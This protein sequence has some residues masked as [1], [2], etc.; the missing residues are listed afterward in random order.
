MKIEKRTLIKCLLSIALFAY[1]LT[2]VVVSRHV[3]AATP[4]NGIDICVN[5]TLNTG[6]ITADDVNKIIGDPMKKLDTLKRGE[7]NTLVI[8]KKLD[9]C[10][11]IESSRVVILANGVLRIDV[12]PMIPVARVFPAGKQSYYVNAA[13]KRITAR[14]DNNIDVPIISGK[15]PDVAAV[16]PLLPM[17]AKLKNDPAAEA[18]A[19]QIDINRRG[20]IT[21]IPA[22]LGHIVVFGDTAD[23]QSKIDRLKTFYR[24][25]MPVKGWNYY[26]TISV[27]W[28]GRIVATR[29]KK[30]VKVLNVVTDT[31]DD[32]PDDAMMTSNPEI[33]R[34]QAERSNK[35][36]QKNANK[37]TN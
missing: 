17:L 23:F 36:K 7:I 18:W 5:D 2:A 22:V 37:A 34:E 8:E 30:D 20:D 15:I 25:V 9:A 35:T 33:M 28:G 6:F 31:I 4:F 19:S 32:V 3:V 29:R 13:G 11:N 1:L 26:D 14:P 27:K 24:E 10:D 12:T 21:I 16:K